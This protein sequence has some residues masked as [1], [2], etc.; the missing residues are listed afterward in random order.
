MIKNCYIHI[1]FC[2][3]ICSYCDFCKIYYYEKIVDKYLE[4]LENVKLIVYGEKEPF[5]RKYIFHGDSAGNR[6]S[7][8]LSAG[9]ISYADIRTGQI[10]FNC[11]YAGDYFL[12]CVGD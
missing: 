4:Q 5:T 12:F 9:S 8:G 7:S 6:I 2:D 11:F 10:W 3:K 1:P